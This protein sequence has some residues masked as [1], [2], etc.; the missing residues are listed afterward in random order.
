MKQLD[1]T[2]MRF[3]K[4]IAIKQNGYDIN[5]SRKHIKWDCVCDCGNY[6]S[7]RLNALRSGGTISCGCAMVGNIKHGMKYTKEYNAWLNIKSRCININNPEYKN[8]GGRGISVCESWINSFEEFYKDMGKKPIST[9][10]DRI[11]NNQGY[12]KENCKWSDNKT[13]SRNK[14]NN[15]FYE[16]NGIRMIISDWAKRNNIGFSSMNQRIN[17]W[18]LEKALL[19]IKKEN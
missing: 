16:I 12:S 6:A 8:Y 1:I 5:P 18:P 9:S 13:Q 15:R 14:R 19:T 4:L 10:I 11:D 7:V 17:K 2:N 3:G